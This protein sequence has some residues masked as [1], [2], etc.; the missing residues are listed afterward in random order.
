MAS[1]QPLA[2]TTIRSLGSGQTLTDPISLLKELIENSLDANATQ[3]TIEASPNFLDTLLVKDNGFGI[4]S[5][6]RAVAC[7]PHYTSKI[8][9]FDDI[10]GVE[11]L[12]FRGEALASAAEMSEGFSFT[13]RC[14]GE[15]VAEVFEIARNGEV[16]EKRSVGAPVGTTMKV[17]GFLKRLPVRRE[18]VLRNQKALMK[19]LRALV[20]TYYLSRPR[21]R[22]AMKILK[23]GETL[24]YAPSKTVPEAV[25]KVVG[26]DAANVC[27]W[28]IKE[29]DGFTVEAFLVKRG[30]EDVTVLE[31]PMCDNYVFV[32]SRPV[33]C[34]KRGSTAQALWKMY[35]K[36]V[37]GIV[38]D[39]KA[40]SNP[41]LYMNIRCPKGIYDVNVEP[42]KDDVFFDGSIVGNLVSIVEELLKEFYGEL[43]EFQ[44]EGATSS[45]QEKGKE[46]SS[47]Q[48]D[49]FDIL[50]ARRK[51]PA[52]DM[53][54]NLPTPP[55][56]PEE[57]PDDIGMEPLDEAAIGT[58]LLPLRSHTDRQI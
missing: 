51:D 18:T 37:K 42:A 45:R 39:T 40:P 33:S 5:V 48:D 31:K 13:T 19:R 21:C 58:P 38:G 54:L 50:L 32:D 53:L 24:V 27:E 47:V 55:P 46:K 49:D 41:L 4:S 35:K 43:A 29:G 3:I 56:P 1:I 7:K 17:T 57:E 26:K 44:R 28:A 22:F 23:G 14:E 10:V 34:T 15:N 30:C 52:Q 6:D 8:T 16:K 9:S 20:A 11:T 12:G 36:C 25:R 2:A